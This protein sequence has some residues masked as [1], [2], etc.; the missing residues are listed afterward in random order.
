MSQPGG[1]VGVGT[2]LGEMDPWLW[3]G[4]EVPRVGGEARF[5]GAL[6]SVGVRAGRASGGPGRGAGTPLNGEVQES[7]GVSSDG[8]AR[9]ELGRENLRGLRHHGGAG[10]AVAGSR[11]SV[12]PAVR[13]FQVCARAPCTTMGRTVP[14]TI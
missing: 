14:F 13:D 6:V 11:S 10:T 9:P 4:L 3:W 7:S 12:F 5:A 2:V 1:G 8:P